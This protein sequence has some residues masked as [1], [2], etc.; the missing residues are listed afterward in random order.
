MVEGACDINILQDVDELSRLAWSAKVAS[1]HY[2]L[3]YFC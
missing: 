1:A 3:E 2:W